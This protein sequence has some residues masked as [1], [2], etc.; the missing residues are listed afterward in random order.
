MLYD[1]CDDMRTDKNTS[2]SYIELYQTL[3]SKKKE[4][5]TCVLEVG[6]GPE[7]LNGG[8]I[9]MW[10]NYFANAT[11]HALDILPLER[12]PLDIRQHPRIH[13]HSPQNAYDL[14]F[15]TNRFEGVTFDL[16]LDD[17]PHTLESMIFFVQHY[18]PLLKDDGILIIEDVQD[19]SWTNDLRSAT[20]LSLQPYIT[21]YDRRSVKGRYDDILF[22]IDKSGA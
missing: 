20:P 5:A 4:T 15:V 16:L 7:S 1:F 6:I 17:G 11:V 12:I 19:I 14:S 10:V 2:H 18:S 8:S 9:M 21:V 22:V 13:V 3:L